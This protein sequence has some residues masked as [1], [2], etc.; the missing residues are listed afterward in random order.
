[1]W[2]TYLVAEVVSADG[3]DGDQFLAVVH[4]HVRQTIQEFSRCRYSSLYITY[5]ES[6]RKKHVLNELDSSVFQSIK[7]LNIVQI[8]AKD[9]EDATTQFFLSKRDTI[10]AYFFHL[11]EKKHL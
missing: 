5:I 2:R 7:K 4:T 10:L 6:I 8:N 3:V 9:E 1:V 11:D